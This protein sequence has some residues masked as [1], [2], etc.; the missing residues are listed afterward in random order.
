MA[1][2]PYAIE[3]VKSAGVAKSLLPA[4]REAASEP[5]TFEHYS[6]A[7]T[8]AF[9]IENPERKTI[10]QDALKQIMLLLMRN[11]EVA[12]SIKTVSID[13]KTPEG[14]ELELAKDDRE[15]TRPF[16]E[17]V[18]QSPDTILNIVCALS[19]VTFDTPDRRVAS[20]YILRVRMYGIE[21]LE[22]MPKQAVKTEMMK[23]IRGLKKNSEKELLR[24]AYFEMFGNE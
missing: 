8:G 19:M 4:L 23:L 5:D 17:A 22:K 6:L 24:S 13:N 2:I 10:H 3:A 20:S 1:F 16:I 7:T 21:M 9:S 14:K 15:R 18:L 11:G 12:N